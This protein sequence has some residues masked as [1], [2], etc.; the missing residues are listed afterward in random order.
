MLTTTRT[1]PPERRGGP[2]RG[3]PR[4][5]YGL[6]IIVVYTI[7]FALFL[8][9]KPWSHAVVVEISDSAGLCGPLLG[10]AFAVGAWGRGAGRSRGLGDGDRRRTWAPHLLGLGILCYALGAAAWTVYELI[11]QQPP[12]PSLADPLYLS[13]TVVD[14]LG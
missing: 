8:T 6:V 4:W 10:V 11:L 3:L 1:G 9:T 13:I 12:F 14:R 7:A 5:S 2:A